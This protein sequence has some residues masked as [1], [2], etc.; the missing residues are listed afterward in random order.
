MNRSGLMKLGMIIACLTIL[1]APVMRK[2]IYDWINLPDFSHGFL[3]P[4]ISV[5]FVYAKRKQLANVS[6]SGQWMGLGVMVSGILLNLVGNL[7]NEYFTTRFSLLVVIGG[8]IFFLLGK[9]FSRILLFP[10]MFLI[11]MIP[12]P[13][14]LMDQISFP[15]QLFA[16]K[17]SAKALYVFGVP[18]LREGNIIQL[19][20]S[21]LEVV[22][23]CSGIRS[24]MSLLT[25]SVLFAYFG[26]KT[27]AKKVLLAV[28]ALPVAI[29][30]NAARVTG[31]GMVAYY[32][33]AA[34]AEGF[35]HGFSGWIIFVVGLIC[36]YVIGIVFS[37]IKM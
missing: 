6:V 31:T 23:A 20:N 28:S 26:Q 30:A 35:F 10:M 11:F 15:M 7:A 4:I 32:Y 5:Y 27:F 24:L 8:I 19:A 37:K 18:A 14:I 12:I 25:L 17:V 34:A 16:S 21:S 36:L 3:I 2:L 1:Y 33:G 13:S 22:E 9:E 29:V